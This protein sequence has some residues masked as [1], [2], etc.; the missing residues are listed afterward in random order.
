MDL[1]RVVR[2]LLIGIAGVLAFLEPTLALQI[3]AGMVGA[4]AIY[5][6]VVELIAA[7]APPPAPAGGSRAARLKPGVPPA[8]NW[9]VP[10]LAAATIG[11]ERGSGG[12]VPDHPGEQA[13]RG[14]AGRP[15]E[16]LQ[17]PP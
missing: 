12:G 5:Y 3:V 9:R 16:E 14:Q 13:R 7:I 15:G 8:P 11:V 6:A 2:A 1:A 17:R 10:A 4:M